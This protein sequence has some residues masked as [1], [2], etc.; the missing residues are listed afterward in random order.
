MISRAKM[1]NSM[2]FRAKMR[3]SKILQDFQD[4]DEIFQ[5]FL[6]KCEKFLSF[7]EF[8]GQDEKL[9]SYPGISK[10]KTRYSR[11]C[12]ANVRNF[13]DFLDFIPSNKIIWEANASPQFCH[14]W[15]CSVSK[16]SQICYDGKSTQT[17]FIAAASSLCSS[18][19]DTQGINDPC[20][21]H[22]PTASLFIG[23]QPIKEQPC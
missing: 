16:M 7:T 10:A 11:I 20:Q 6:G 18:R 22:G 1:R 14:P 2:I 21:G 4:H 19:C 8:P 23:Q 9:L 13:R 3:N 17:I 15:S 5:D 12:R